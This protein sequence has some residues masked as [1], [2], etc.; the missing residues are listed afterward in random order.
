MSIKLKMNSRTE[1]Y[2]VKDLIKEYIETFDFITV[3]EVLNLTNFDGSLTETFEGDDDKRGWRWSDLTGNNMMVRTL[4]DG[5]TWLYLC[6]PTLEVKKAGGGYI[7]DE[8]TDKSDSEK[9]PDDIFLD[10]LYEMCADLLEV[11]SRKNDGRRKCMVWRKSKK[12]GVLVE[13]FPCWFHCWSGNRVTKD[14]GSTVDQ[15]LAV[16]EF[17]DGHVERIN[18]DHIRFVDEWD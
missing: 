12:K 6:D 16:C 10:K 9:S 4:K 8:L 1:A 15:L 17:Q 14:D 7:L 13:E 5:T 11:M 2:S 18:F 3:R